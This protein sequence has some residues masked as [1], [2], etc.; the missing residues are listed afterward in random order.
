M[1][2]A[3][4]KRGVVGDFK[5][6]SLLSAACLA[7]SLQGDLTCGRKVGLVGSVVEMRANG[8]MDWSGWLQSANR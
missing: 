6:R 5:N 7:K 2:S 8:S 1:Q 4:S 3:H